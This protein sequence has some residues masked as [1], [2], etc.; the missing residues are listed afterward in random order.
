MAHMYGNNAIE[1]LQS[2]IDKHKEME[3]T[4]G[5]FEEVINE[6]SSTITDNITT[7]ARE[8]LEEINNEVLYIESA[9]KEF[10]ADRRGGVELFVDSEIENG[11]EM[12]NV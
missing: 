7:K 3:K 5:D 1:L 10:T 4:V 11:K 2:L 8:V 12:E 9:I 6:Y